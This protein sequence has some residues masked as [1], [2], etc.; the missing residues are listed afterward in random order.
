MG[1]T[2]RMAILIL[3]VKSFYGAMLGKLLKAV[4][5]WH[6]DSL[7][8]RMGLTAPFPTSNLLAISMPLFLIF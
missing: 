7:D 1:K 2:K 5:R 3:L 6:K 8:K 4:A